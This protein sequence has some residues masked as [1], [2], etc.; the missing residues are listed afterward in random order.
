MTAWLNAIDCLQRDQQACVLVTI[1]Q[2]WG[3][4]P[5]ETGT[6]MVVGAKQV[7]GTIGGGTLEQQAIQ[8]ARQA[9]ASAEASP[10]R[11]WWDEWIL[12]PDLGQ[13]CGGVVK[14]Y[15]EYIPATPQPWQSALK[16]TL[17]ANQ[18]AQIL[19]VLDTDNHRLKHKQINALSTADQASIKME[20]AAA[21]WLLEEIILPQTF[22]LV[23][24]GAGHVGQALV[25]VMSQF[26]CRLIWID[27]RAEQFP[28]ALPA[29]SQASIEMRVEVDPVSVIAHMP[30]ASDYRVMTHDHALDLEL[31]AAILARED[32]HSIGVIGSATKAARFR[33]RLRDRGFTPAQL[34]RLICP[35][36]IAEI[37][38]K[39]PGAIAIAVAAQL[40]SWHSSQGMP[41]FN[42]VLSS[43]QLTE[44]SA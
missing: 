39:H 38:S 21:E 13:C 16:Q 29:F 3:S 43:S 35:I 22:T 11:G 37:R 7:I 2:T 9:L 27:S 26:P 17:Q 5:R 14:V 19:T 15:Y 20:T 41:A 1:V 28:S 10:I 31:C 34:Q 18:P 42:P 6:K 4:T 8:T 23:L 24:F 40:L 30:A 44:C 12:G 33:H 36:G 32:V 25:N